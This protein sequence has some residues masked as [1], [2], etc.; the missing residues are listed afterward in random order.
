MTQLSQH[1]TLEEF[2]RSEWAA[3]HG[4]PNSP[5]SDTLQHLID[6]AQQME[7]VRTLLG[8][9][10]ITVLSGFRSGRVNAAVGGAPLSAH[11]IGY[12]VD[13]VCPDFGT[14]FEIANFLEQQQ[15][16]EFDQLIYEFRDWVH[17]SF[18]PQM[19]RQCL[20]IRAR[21]EGYVNGIVNF[22]EAA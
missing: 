12:A 14:P 3:R 6:T 16:L 8:D 15:A 17:I 18:D 21:A 7:Q 11:L 1:F 2:T 5:N 22:P 9:R 19:R 13:F 20:S 4:L 10:P